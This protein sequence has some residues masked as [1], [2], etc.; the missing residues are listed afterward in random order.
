MP[1]LSPLFPLCSAALLLSLGCKANSP[2]PSTAVNP[3]PQPAVKPAPPTPL[4]Q[5][6]E[7]LGSNTTWD[8]QWDAVIEK[9]LPPELL[10]AQA[11]HAVRPFCPRFAELPE[12]DKRAFWAYTFQALAAAEA[13][14]NPTSDVHHT[15]AAVNTIDPVTHARSHQAGL[16]QLKYEDAQ[17]YGCPFDFAHDRTLP[18]KDP[19]RTILQPEN[20]L[21]CGLRIMGNQIITQGKP[22]VSRTSY[23]ATLQPGTVSY[24]VFAKQMANVPSSCG[25]HEHRRGA[26]R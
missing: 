24:R 21:A 23:W 8:P 18:A 26:R 2:A 15:A 22:L 5:K 9:G 14:L 19:N 16:L 11:A 17:R 13:G 12:A 7:E 6:K 4:A 10:S 25:L 3:A 20:N 1:R